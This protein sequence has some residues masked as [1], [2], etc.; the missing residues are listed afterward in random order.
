[1][2][3]TSLRGVE[4]NRPCQGHGDG[5]PSRNRST[6]SSHSASDGPRYTRLYR[7]NS[8]QAARAGL[9]RLRGEQVRGVVRR[10][11]LGAVDVRVA[12]VLAHASDGK[13]PGVG[14]PG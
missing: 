3:T 4:P 5:S 8:V 6:A 14:C 9:H 13:I 2:T 7:S 1:M 11:G 10:G 12:W